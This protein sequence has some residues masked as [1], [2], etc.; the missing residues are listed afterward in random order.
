MHVFVPKLELRSLQTL[1]AMKQIC[2][3]FSLYISALTNENATRH[4]C[5]TSDLTEDLTGELFS[6][7]LKANV[8][9][10]SANMLGGITGE[11]VPW[12]VNQQCNLMNAIFS[13][14]V[15]QQVQELRKEKCCGCTVPQNGHDFLSF[16]DK[17]SQFSPMSKKYE[18]AVKSPTSPRPH[19]LN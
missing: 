9:L 19:R 2:S 8:S 17:S 3:S 4:T 13:Q 6:S 16:G 12:E 15:N 18:C 14:V 11:I 7:A 10:H 1:R 5:L